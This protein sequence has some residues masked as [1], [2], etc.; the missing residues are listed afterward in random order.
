MKKYSISLKYIGYLLTMKTITVL[1]F[2]LLNSTTSI[3][4]FADDNKI[5]VYSNQEIGETNKNIFGNNLLGYEGIPSNSGYG[6]WNWRRNEPVQGVVNLAKEAGISI[7]RFP[8]GCGSHDYNWKNTVGL[9]R[10]HFLYGMDEFLK[11]CEKVGAEAIITLSY[12]TGNEHDDADLVEYLNSPNNGS[13]PNGGI[14][15]AK[16]RAYN[17]H[18]SP[19]KINYFEIGNEIYHGNHRGIKEVLPE[20]YARRYLKY[21]DAMKAV[22]PSIKIGVVLDPQ[23]IPNCTR[24]VLE[25][26]K[27]KLDFGII[28]SYPSPVAMT[29]QDKLGKMDASPS[30]I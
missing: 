20:E 12:F 6:I 30:S 19:Y 10:N 27:D 1:V 11:T 17:G 18:P 26:I 16:K 13:N 9:K 29:N 14:D 7:L 3:F 5:I 28:H 15:W 23:Y 22:D 25:I 24:R 2:F 4:V 21:Y 8:G